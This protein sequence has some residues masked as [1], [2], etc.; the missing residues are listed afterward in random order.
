MI[1]HN[2]N[3]YVTP[4]E[5][6]EFVEKARTHFDQQGVKFDAIVGMPGSYPLAIVGSD[7]EDLD[8][9]R[10]TLDNRKKYLAIGRIA[11][12]HTM[13]EYSKKCELHAANTVPNEKF[14]VAAMFDTTRDNNNPESFFSMNKIYSAKKPKIIMPWE[15][16][17][18]AR[19]QIA[20]GEKPFIPVYNE[21]CTPADGKK[22]SPYQDMYT[23]ANKIREY[24]T[25][26]GSSGQYQKYFGKARG[27]EILAYHCADQNN[28]LV[29]PDMQNNMVAVDDIA[30]TGKGMRGIR[31]Y[32]HVTFATLD[33]REGTAL[34]PEVFV[35]DE[36]ATGK[37]WLVYMNDRGHE[38]WGTT[39]DKVE[40]STTI[41]KD[42]NDVRS[43]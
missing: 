41:L 30:E 17:G 12:P 9:V 38:D 14:A 6:Q 21:Q 34:R 2:N 4:T 43:L 11:T 13:A 33:V 23:L 18:E 26:T 39:Y 5:V 27:G 29:V 24:M 40:C 22:F 3:I 36:K 16:M 8:V 10:S 37:D 15:V 42:L 1:W 25:S 31:E 32:D 35:H 28:G 7:R 19:E 20:R